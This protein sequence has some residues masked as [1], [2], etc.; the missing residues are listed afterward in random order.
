MPTKPPQPPPASKQ[1][2]TTVRELLDPGLLARRPLSARTLAWLAE[3]ADG[4]RDEDLVITVN[5]Q[6]KLQLKLKREVPEGKWVLEVY[7]KSR[8]RQERRPLKV[9]IPVDWD[10]MFLTESA[11]E[12]FVF[13][14]YEAQRLLT[15][16]EI[17]ALKTA[18]YS[19]PEVVGVAHKPPSRPLLLVKRGDTIEAE[20]FP[21]GAGLEIEIGDPEHLEAY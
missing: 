21:V 11:V 8:K 15:K 19:R 5:E 7:T 3:G 6:G 18:F 20:E 16:T 1:P 10:A 2:P 12:K 14:Y 13:P 17:S 9:T 4:N